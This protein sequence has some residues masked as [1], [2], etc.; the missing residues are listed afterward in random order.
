MCSCS[1]GGGLG[2]GG[3]LT[4]GEGV[5]HDRFIPGKDNVY[6]PYFDVFGHMFRPALTAQVPPPA[7]HPPIAIGGD[8]PQLL[9]RMGGKPA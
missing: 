9:M 3:R 8:I 6:S 2:L 5:P 1:Q 7:L 4:R